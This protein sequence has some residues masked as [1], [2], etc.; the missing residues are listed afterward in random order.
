MTYPKH[1]TAKPFFLIVTDLDAG[2]FCIE[3]PMT[4]DALWNLA[5]GRA[6]EK[7]RSVQCGP[8]GPNRDTL[9]AEYRQVH[10]L[11]G[12]PPGSIVRPRG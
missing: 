2:F 1:I 5:A 4:D 12:V 6:R 7:G 8:T 10:K 11:A 9:S 3:G